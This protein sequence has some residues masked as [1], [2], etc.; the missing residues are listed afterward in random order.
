MSDID[1]SISE[2]GVHPAKGSQPL[3]DIAEKRL[4]EAV[5]GYLRELEE[6]RHPDRRQWLARYSDIA[7]E[8]NECLE[9]LAFVHE[10]ADSIHA[11]LPP[12]QK[13][14]ISPWTSEPVGDFQIVKEI[15]RG[16]MG[17]IYEAIQLSLNRHVAL[18]V[19][20]F[21]AS[22]D[23]MCLQRFRQE[24]QAAAQLHH[25]HIVPSYAVG[26]D[27]GIHYYAMQLIE[28]LSLDRIVH[29]MR[30][31]SPVR[32]DSPA[33]SLEGTISDTISLLPLRDE[34]RSVI[35]AEPVEKKSPPESRPTV[36]DS[37][38]AES[39]EQSLLTH[40]SADLSMQ[41]G[42][43]KAKAYRAVVRLMAQAA[44]ALEYAHNQ[45]II[46]RDIKPANLLVDMRHNLWITDFGLA[47]LH[48]DQNLTRTGDL[49]GTI[50][51]AS[52]EQVSGQKVL[53][54][55][56]TDLYSLGATFYEVITLKPVFSGTNRH[57]L[58]EQVLNTDPVR[59]RAIDRAIPPELETILLKLLDK[60]PAGRYNSAQALADDLHRFLR[61]EPIH[62]KPPTLLEQTRKWGRRHPAYVV[63]FIFGMFLTLMVSGVSN[64]LISQANNRTKA[65][66][67]AE[68]MRAEEAERRF[69][70]ARQAVD[71]MIEVSE[72]DLDKPPTQS[73]QKR[74]L[75]T[76]LVFYQDF[77]AQYEGDP[78]RESELLSVQKRLQKVLEDLAVL[79]G[80]GQF[81]LLGEK[82]VQ[83]DLGLDESRKKRIDAITQEFNR[84]G[85]ALSRSFQDL[86]P[87]ERREKFLEF[88]RTNERVVKS[89]LNEKQLKRLDQ[90]RL[91]L[92]GFTAFGEPEV[93]STLKLADSQRQ[94]LRQIEGEAFMLMKDG[95]D[96]ADET[97]R[98]ESRGN[99]L[100]SAMGKSLAL[101]TPVQLSQWHELI[102]SPFEGKLSNDLPGVPPQP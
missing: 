52:P 102:G 21:A 75:E 63:A 68:R 14:D 84:Q 39:A 25:N 96:I 45:G 61:D 81:I 1:D 44:E 29:E 69:A 8:L 26:C 56:R 66:L 100:R 6:G 62:A 90:I 18:K 79:E 71:I 73:L 41:H 89:I 92:Q 24:A 64:W 19:L 7:H 59:P 93:V 50:R 101:L 40:L 82:S 20:P 57:A 60:T 31:E 30:R 36:Q 95:G 53:L 4:V 67:A 2:T 48:G 51:Y 49:V 38:L 43:E 47:H 28:G 65:A 85:P 9:G 77:I 5:Q 42:R 80:A 22:I 33:S 70:Q 34:C 27:R 3:D 72:N 32:R 13:V 35:P 16:G 83:A 15:G 87:A 46:H 23:S 98:H 76:A 86:T 12:S 58:L 54:D 99:V 37:T 74:L 91:Q 88:A 97:A 10:A 55:H 17:I 94:A 78:N 11:S